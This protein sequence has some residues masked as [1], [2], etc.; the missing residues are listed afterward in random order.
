MRS[1][2]SFGLIDPIIINQDGTII[3]GH[4]R[5]KAA[6]HLGI[7][8][9]PCVVLDITKDKEKALNLALNRI[10]GEWDEKLLVELLKGME[11]EDRMLSGFDEKELQVLLEESETGKDD[12]YEPAPP[13]NPKSKQGDVYLL[14]NHRL[15]CGDSTSKDD[16]ARLMDG[17]RCQMV[18]TD[19]PYNVDY[20][21]GT[22]TTGQNK[23]E[24]I[25]NDK[26]SSADFRE[27]LYRV[28]LNLNENCDGAIYICMSSS[29][30]VN[31]KA[32]FEDAGGHYQSFIIWVKNTFTLSRSDFQN[33]YEP[34]L[35]GWPKG[36]KNHYFVGHRNK[37]NV[38]ED[39]ESLRP[40]Y[41]D[42]KTIVNLGEYKLII[43]GK[44]SGK[45]MP[46]KGKTDIWKEP[47]PTKSSE[48][49]TMKPIQLVMRAIDASSRYGDAVLDLFGGSGSTLIAC[50]QAGRKCY[51]MEL[52]PQYVD[53]IIDRWQKFT[54][55]KA[56]KL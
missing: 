43:D 41:E 35:Y 5:V 25:K 50:E 52:D 46:M 27:F 34:I 14:G 21:G 39:I 12:E 2:E 3:G 40:S 11:I 36:V 4:Q 33:R 8:E 30:L 16:V 53:V 28:C 18:F 29:E 38:W 44:V 42:G 32:A 13:K 26:M 23:R 45:V 49:P 22:N 24:G 7:E 48:H 9:V 37:S 47:K 31:L 1:I 54:G 56:K 51:T 20:Q 15:M 55:Q 19:P 17:A 6:E 10:S